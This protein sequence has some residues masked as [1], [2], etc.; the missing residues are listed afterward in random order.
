[1]RELRKVNERIAVSLDIVDGLVAM[2]FV[3]AWRELDSPAFEQG[4]IDPDTEFPFDGPLVTQEKVKH[5]PGDC[6]FPML[7]FEQEACTHP[8]I[9]FDG[10]FILFRIVKVKVCI[11]IIGA[12]NVALRLA[13]EQMV[14][15]ALHRF[16]AA[17]P[18]L[19][20]DML[21]IHLET[22]FKCLQFVQ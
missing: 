17:K 6:S 22:F 7:W 8:T 3:Q 21:R 1:M 20:Y 4:N 10:F 16:C 12:G 11:W 18:R 9:I 13:D 5:R 19:R 14:Q 2:L 15:I